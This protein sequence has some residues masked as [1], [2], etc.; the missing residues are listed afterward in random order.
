VV[1]DANRRVLRIIEGG[2]STRSRPDGAP[3]MLELTEGNC[4]FTLSG[5]KARHCL[6]D[7]SNANAQGQYYLTDL[8]EPSATAGARS[9]RSPDGGRCQV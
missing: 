1:R 4:R 5:G 7:L 8:V 3:G 2:I 9:A 6:R